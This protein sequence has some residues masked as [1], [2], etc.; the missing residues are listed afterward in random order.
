[1]VTICHPE[2]QGWSVQQPSCRVVKHHRDLLSKPKANFSERLRK[3]REGRDSRDLTRRLLP[4]GGGNCYAVR[5]LPVQWRLGIHGEID[6]P[7]LAGDLAKQKIAKGETSLREGE[8]A[9]VHYGA[10]E[11]VLQ[12]CRRA[13]S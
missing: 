8:K 5:S 4:D 3:P 13:D 6:N 7:A 9:A 10:V 11:Q 12:P 1:M 2:V